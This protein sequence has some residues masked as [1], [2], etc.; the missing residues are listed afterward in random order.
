MTHLFLSLEINLLLGVIAL[1]VR[2]VNVPGMVAGV[3]IGAV[4]YTRAGLQGYVPF[5]VLG[6][7]AC[8]AVRFAKRAPDPCRGTACRALPPPDALPAVGN[9][10]RAAASIGVERVLAAMLPAAFVCV[11]TAFPDP[12]LGR[13]A[14]VFGPPRDCMPN[15]G[16]RG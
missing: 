15:W 2:T 13:V 1:I 3:L 12:Q 14:A 4:I 5:A 8:A 16:R 6:L 9:I 11:W 10:S 7:L